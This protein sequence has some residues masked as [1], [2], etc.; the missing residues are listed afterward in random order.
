MKNNLKLKTNTQSNLP[1]L[2]LALVFGVTALTVFV[3]VM[4]YVVIFV[5][6]AIA[7]EYDFR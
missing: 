7:S 3:L 5:P 4:M 2:V 1:G 6:E